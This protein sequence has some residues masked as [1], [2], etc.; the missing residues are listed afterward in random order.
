MDN[1]SDINQDGDIIVTTEQG[2]STFKYTFFEHDIF[3]I[4]L[5]VFDDIAPQSALQY[6]MGNLS[7]LPPAYSLVF[8]PT[9]SL[10]M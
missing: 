3:K 6:S 2:T 4:N 7:P 5:A 8:S 10:A 1:Y 9:E